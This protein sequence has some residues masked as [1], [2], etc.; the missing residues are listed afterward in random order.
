MART[1]LGVFLDQINVTNVL[2]VHL[3]RLMGLVSVKKVDTLTNLK[4]GA[5][6]VMSLV[7]HARVP[8]SV[9]PAQVDPF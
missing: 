7:R 4:T 3:Y 8:K 2:Q 9:A 5:Y 1:A 6:C